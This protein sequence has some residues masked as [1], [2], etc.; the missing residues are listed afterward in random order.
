MLLCF[1][2]VRFFFWCSFLWGGSK[3]DLLMT[4][5]WMSHLCTCDCTVEQCTTSPETA[6]SLRR[7]VSVNQGF[8]S[9]LSAMPQD[10]FLIFQ[11]STWPPQFLLTA[12]S[13]VFAIFSCIVGTTWFNF[14][15][16]VYL[17]RGIHVCWLLGQGS[18]FKI[19][20]ILHFTA[21]PCIIALTANDLGLGYLSS[22]H[23]LVLF[24]ARSLPI[25]F[26]E[27]V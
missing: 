20:I 9:A 11:T 13:E 25:L 24:G 6:T 17:F 4:H 5:P 8:K 21:W 12:S 27:I 2:H 7:S 10:V 3:K 19:L 23:S 14:Q 18:S 1:L 26:S 16:A 15:S 22:N